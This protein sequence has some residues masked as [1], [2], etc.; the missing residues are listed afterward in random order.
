MNRVTVAVPR[1]CVG[2][3]NWVRLSLGNGLAGKDGHAYVVN[4]H[5]DRPNPRGEEPYGCT[6]LKVHFL[7]SRD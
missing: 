4:P 1:R 3:P 5:N 2:T 6:T 7:G